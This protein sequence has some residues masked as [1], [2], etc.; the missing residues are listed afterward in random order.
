MAQLLLLLLL[1]AAVPCSIHDR[2]PNVKLSSAQAWH[3]QFNLAHIHVTLP[4][5]TL[6]LQL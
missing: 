6:L 4:L 5:A 3:L 1:A 2:G